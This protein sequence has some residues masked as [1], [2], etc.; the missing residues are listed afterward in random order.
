MKSGTFFSSY[1]SVMVAVSA[2]CCDVVLCV[3]CVL[4]TYIPAQHK[5]VDT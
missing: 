1:M 4:S 5:G 3:A 2:V